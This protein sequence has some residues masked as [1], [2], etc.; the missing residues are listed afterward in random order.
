MKDNL[1]EQAYDHAI[2]SK[3]LDTMLYNYI[4]KNF[5]GTSK[6][7]D[8]SEL[9]KAGWVASILSD[10]KTDI[11]KQRAQIFA[12]LLYLL[13]SDDVNCNK[14]S[15]IIFSRTGNLLATKFLSVLYDSNSH[16]NLSHIKFKHEFGTILDY[17][18]GLKRDENTIDLNQESIVTTDFQRK[19]W[20]S[21]LGQNNVSISAPTS[22][23]KSFIIQSYIKYKFDILKKFN[24]LYIVPSKALLNQVS[25][26][27]RRILN[28]EI[29]IKTAFIN[30]QVDYDNPK[31]EKVMYVLTP[32]RC[33]NVLYQKN[34]SF[35]PDFIFIDEIQ[36]IEDE[37]GRGVL[38]EYVLNDL[39]KAWPKTTIVTAGPNISNSDTLFS[40]IFNKECV[41]NET[42]LS[43]VFQIK[44]I[45]SPDFIYNNLDLKVTSLQEKAQGL[46]IS[47]PVD[48]N[49]KQVADSN[50]GTLMSKI[51][52]RIA[53]GEQSII[54]S[55]RTD[56]AEKWALV[57]LN[58]LE[59]KASNALR[60]LID[61]LKEEIHPKY[62]LVKCLEY[63]VAFHHS[64]LPELVR[65]EI[66]SLF[67][68]GE[69][70]YL[71][72]TSTLIQG[73]NLPAKNL[74]LIY[75][76]KRTDELSPFEFGNL[77]GRAGRIKDSLYGSIYFVAKNNSDK[78]IAEKYFAENYQ[79]EVVLASTKSLKKDGFIENELKDRAL[80]VTRNKS[81]HTITLLKHKYLS[82]ENELETYLKN[83]GLDKSEIAL[84]IDELESQLFNIEL[85]YEVLKLNPSVDPMLQNKLY[86][87]IK[88]EGI[89][90]WV[91]S[92]NSN[93]Y[94]KIR[95]VDL[96]NYEFKDLSF[97]WQFSILCTKINDVFEVTK[98]TY[99]KHNIKKLYMGN[100]SHFGFR[101]LQNMSFREIIEEDINYY[102][103]V[104]EEIDAENENDIN[105]R[106]N[107]VMKVHSKVITFTLVKYFKVLADILAYSLSEEEK[108][109]YKLILSL[110][111]MLELGTMEP[112]MIQLISLGINRSVALKVFNE[113][114]KEHNYLERDVIEWLFTKGSNLQMK[115]IYIKYL[116]E[117]GY[118]R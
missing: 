64:K 92:P 11:H 108:E 5:N 16:K 99:F 118:I 29:M 117:L 100:I 84:I 35:S 2:F 71:Y 19:L 47:L 27:F 68:S 49:V 23:G 14:M 3:V 9:K 101:W 1:C 7:I 78:I 59:S 45:V 48:F 63:R 56:F 73:V 10:S 65:K 93:F 98:E 31:Y 38:L 89:I 33:L 30:T 13:Y 104:R 116:R 37:E 72:C 113:F 6:K 53:D 69:I 88:E 26:Q 44:A 109:K 42:S 32:E 15:Y 52:K 12:S 20:E 115:P 114:K 28:K 91:I 50:S 34:D 18:V 46:N 97:Y 82:G 75:P 103:N 54:Y 81:G 95:K 111:I 102:A 41:E 62:Y 90:N 17:E 86:Q 67:D 58:S 112:I 79:K 107:N 80:D 4:A 85:P 76:K 74:F 43:P 36:N 66:E 22:S 25:E 110:P 94:K 21:L 87:I 96:E 83:K 57:H 40:N 61:Y 55:P 106:I 60:E 24:V 8:M 70:L 51:V 105:K 39:S 77:I